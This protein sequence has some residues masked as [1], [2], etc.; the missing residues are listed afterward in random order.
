M[1][2]DER[3]CTGIREGPYAWGRST[4]TRRDVGLGLGDGYATQSCSVWISR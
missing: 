2:L 1:G 4:E 3:I